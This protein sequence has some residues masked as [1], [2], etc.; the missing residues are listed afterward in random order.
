[1]AAYVIYNPGLVGMAEMREVPVGALLG[2]APARGV[3]PASLGG[4][5]GDVV[6]RVRAG[7]WFWQ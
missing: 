7:M 5:N 3:R 2:A 4:V 1:M 6:V